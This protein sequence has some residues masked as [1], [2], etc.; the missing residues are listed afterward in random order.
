MTPFH[1]V[2]AGLGIPSC[3]LSLQT[4][5]TQG[6]VDGSRSDSSV[7]LGAF[8]SAQWSRG[9]M[10][11]TLRTYRKFLDRKANK[12]SEPFS[13]SLVMFA[14]R[15]GIQYL[16][17]FDTSLSEAGR[18]LFGASSRQQDHVERRGPAPEIPRPLRN[19]TGANRRAAEG[20]GMMF[21][22]VVE[23]IGQRTRLARGQMSRRE[24]VSL[25]GVAAAFP[26]AHA[27]APRR[28]L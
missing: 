27:S 6:T 18:T 16:K 12:K 24:I 1:K 2:S 19:R 5:L 14:D 20:V 25:A 28:H 26:A 17:D 10:E 11:A 23:A 22:G 4:A 8:D 21:L 3:V 9:L 15:K 7:L 13:P